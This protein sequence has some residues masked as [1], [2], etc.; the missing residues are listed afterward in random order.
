MNTLK[1]GDTV[2]KI[3]SENPGLD[4]ILKDIGFP[5]I[6]NP[7]LRNTAGKFM[8]L[9]KGAK[10]KG[11]NIETLKRELSQRGYTVE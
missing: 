3:L 4:L 1:L 6:V 5:D 9:E 8:T 2:Y 11:V 10:L 7:I